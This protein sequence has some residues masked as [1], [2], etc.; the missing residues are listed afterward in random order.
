MG[1]MTRIRERLWPRRGGEAAK[2]VAAAELSHDEAI[3]QRDA[4]V[5]LRREADQAAAVIAAHNAANRY[6]D[7]IRAVMG[8]KV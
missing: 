2:A 1:W 4:M 3:I 5:E 6:D 8:G 7:W